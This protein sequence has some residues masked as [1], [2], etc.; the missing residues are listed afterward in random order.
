M[1][2]V[3]RSL[4]GL[5][6][7]SSPED[8]RRAVFTES[9]GIGVLGWGVIGLTLAMSIGSFFAPLVPRA[10][11]V[12]GISLSIAAI[13]FAITTLG[14]FGVLLMLWLIV[15]AVL[16]VLRQDPGTGRVRTESEPISP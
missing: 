1:W 3:S 2:R 5:R 4:S 16:L 15:A 13:A 14:A 7:P 10:M 8:S 6:H 9:A 12:V 11:A